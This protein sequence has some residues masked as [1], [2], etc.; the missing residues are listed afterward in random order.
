MKTQLTFAER[1]LLLH[2]K[3]VRILEQITENRRLR[4][5]LEEDALVNAFDR[6]MPATMKRLHSEMHDDT[7]KECD[8]HRDDLLKEYAEIMEALV[9][10]IVERAK[11]F[12][13]E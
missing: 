2:N 12:E 1:Q 9:K 4:K 5:S 13:N 6:T 8:K 7:I 11:M 10:P 3:C